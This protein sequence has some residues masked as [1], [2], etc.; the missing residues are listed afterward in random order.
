MGEDA[1]LVAKVQFQVV[2]KTHRNMAILTT[3]KISEQTRIKLL[4][5]NVC[6]ITLMK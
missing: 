1:F 2:G 3:C 6:I 5:C 4:I